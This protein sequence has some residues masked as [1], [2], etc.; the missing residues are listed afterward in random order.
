[1]AHIPG[2][3]PGKGTFRAM[4]VGCRE[5]ERFFEC[6]ALELAEK[7]VGEYLYCHET[8]IAVRILETEA[9]PVDDASVYNAVFNKEPGNPQF[10]FEGGVILVCN[11]DGSA[12]EKNFFNSVMYITAGKADSGDVVLLRSCEPIEGDSLINS[13][14][15]VTYNYHWLGALMK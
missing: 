11:R 2:G 4:Y 8:H 10:K 1:M 12:P 14:Y 6:G 7:L 13:F 15:R 3:R 5:E 9:Y